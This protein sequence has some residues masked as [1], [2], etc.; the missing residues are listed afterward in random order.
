[1][2]ALVFTFATC[3]AVATAQQ[4]TKIPRIGYLGGSGSAESARTGAFRQGLDELGYVE[5]KS[6]V[7]ERRYAERKRDR[8]RALAAE[9]VRLKVNVIVTAGS[10]ST[11]AAKQATATIPIVMA[12]DRSVATNPPGY[13]FRLESSSETQKC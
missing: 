13:D 12:Q 3:G 2:V 4:P 10:T 7:I 1:M 8:E 6:I 11:R 5:G 9:L